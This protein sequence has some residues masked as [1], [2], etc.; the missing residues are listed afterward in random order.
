MK[1]NMI[2]K[3]LL[4]CN[5]LVLTPSIIEVLPALGVIRIGFPVVWGLWWYLN[6]FYGILISIPAIVIITLITIFIIIYDYK[7]ED[8]T[9]KDLVILI[10]LCLLNILACL[11]SREIA[12]CA[13][14]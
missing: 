6:A 14:V 8:L 5:L 10:I 3:I 7:K 11:G 1:K 2:L 13:S 12:E 9:E 4:C